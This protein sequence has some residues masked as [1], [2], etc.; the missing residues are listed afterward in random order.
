[1]DEAGYL[2]ADEHDISSPVY[3]LL[4]GHDVEDFKK[5]LEK[6]GLTMKKIVPDGNC[7]F[8]AIA[9]FHYCDE[10]FHVQMRKETMNYIV[11][12]L[13]NNYFS[14]IYN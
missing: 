2:S 10:S 4:E 11:S 7:L 9:H 5:Q 6:V 14:V 3:K 8:R 1:M 12:T 13:S